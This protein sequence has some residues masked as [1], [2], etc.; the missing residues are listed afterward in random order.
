MKVQSFIKA[1]LCEFAKISDGIWCVGVEELDDHITLGCFDGC[2]P[3]SPG[4]RRC[5]LVVVVVEVVFVEEEGVVQPG[6]MTMAV[7]VDN[8][9][10]GGN[11]DFP[12]NFSCYCYFYQCFS[13]R[14][15]MLDCEMKPQ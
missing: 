12:C 13:M 14:Y 8:D 3:L 10:G 9:G 11:C 2:C 4:C 6:T 7:D 15:S 1:L 5:G